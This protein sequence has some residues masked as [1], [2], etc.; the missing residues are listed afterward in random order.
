VGK[1][2]PVTR[3]VMGDSFATHFRRYAVHHTPKGSVRPR[4]DA[5]AFA[6]FLERASRSDPVE[7]PWAVEV[8]RYEAAWLAAAAPGFRWIVRCFRYPI[9]H[10]PRDPAQ[11]S[12]EPLPQPTLA[13]WCR[14]SRR[15]RLRHLILPLPRRRRRVSH[16]L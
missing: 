6:I 1:H 16:R 14:L 7:P 5:A 3:R 4:E 9:P 12:F 8:A 2:L 11:E 10:L 13:I 15:S